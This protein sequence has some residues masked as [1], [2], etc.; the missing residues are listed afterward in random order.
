MLVRALREKN[1]KLFGTESQVQRKHHLLIGFVELKYS[2][3][4]KRGNH[5]QIFFFRWDLIADHDVMM[6]TGLFCLRVSSDCGGYLFPKAKGAHTG[7]ERHNGGS[8]E[9]KGMAKCNEASATPDLAI[10]TK[11]AGRN[12]SSVMDAQPCL[13]N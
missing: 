13:F 3:S 7:T 1:I 12:T 4:L 11:S 2:V 6:M 9:W 8:H 10:A 5:Q